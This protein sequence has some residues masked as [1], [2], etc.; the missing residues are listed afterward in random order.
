[1]GSQRPV[2]FFL[3]SDSAESICGNLPRSRGFLLCFVFLL[4]YCESERGQAVRS[5]VMT[6]VGGVG[7]KREEGGLRCSLLIGY[8]PFGAKVVPIISFFFVSCFRKKIKIL[9]SVEKRGDKSK[10]II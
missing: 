9:E 5:R 7:D 1:M 6:R 10:V 8:I 3:R 2:I 4:P